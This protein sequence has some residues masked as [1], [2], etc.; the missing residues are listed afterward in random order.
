MVPTM[1]FRDAIPRQFLAC[2]EQYDRHDAFR[3]KVDGAWVD[4]SHR[5]MLDE[6]HA[7]AAALKDL[8]IAKTDR[9]ALLSENRLEWVATDL[10]ILFAGGVTVPIYPT[11]IPHQVEYILRDADVRAIFVSTKVQAAKIAEL[12]PRLPLLEHVIAFDADAAGEGVES[13]AS[14]V[15]RGRALDG[16]PAAADMAGETSPGDWA[17]IVYTSGTTGEPKGV[18]LTHRNFTSNVRMCLDAFQIGPG[19]VYLSVLPLCHVFERTAGFYTMMTAGVQI[20][21]AE[22]IETAM[23]NLKEIRPTV[24]CFVPRIYEKFYAAVQHAVEGSSKVR[25]GLFGW[26]V[27]VGTA[28]VNARFA[29][30]F[31]PLLRL[32]HRIALALVFGKVRDRVGGRIRFFVSGSAPLARHIIEFFHAA[33]L[34]ILEGYGLTE[35]S[36][37]V[38]VNTF[39]HM[40]FGT[41]GRPLKGEEVRIADDGEI[42]VRGENIMQGYLKKAD[43]TAAVLRDGW[44]YTGDIG[45]IDRDGFLIITDRK[46]D[47]IATAGGK[48]VAP[49]PIENRLKNNLFIAEAVMVGNGR[50][51]ITLLIV[52]NFPR[53]DAWATSAGLAVDDRE[54]LIAS[55]HVVTLYQGIVDQANA[56]LAQYQR[57]KAFTLLPGEL[58]TA[59]GDLT[60]TLKVRRKVVEERYRDRIDAM[61][62]S[63]P[64]R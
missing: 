55:P 29:R 37:V 51:Y 24:V 54:A 11:L 62:R 17:S 14:F 25:R 63:H 7:L 12:R 33:G 53:L 64:P 42:V 50:P 10:G 27:R 56:E 6:V 58:T 1:E 40:R 59:S 52:P 26:G 32:Q 30:R 41:V 45:T 22:S 15:A 60:P 38:S 44:F 36:P 5:E 3:H 8:K 34:P 23:T 4:V 9:V 2:V 16:A 39:E 43:D 21:Y 47:L 18:I 19:D 31:S 61:Y 28:A 49:Q 35:T 46:K 20:A 48:K 13:F 57:I